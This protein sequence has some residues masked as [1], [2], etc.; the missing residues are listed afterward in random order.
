MRSAFHLFPFLLLRRARS[1]RVALLLFSGAIGS[2]RAAYASAQ[3]HG[4]ELG[5]GDISSGAI[6]SVGAPPSGS[7][8]AVFAISRARASLAMSPVLEER[9]NL[10]EE[11]RRGRPMLIVGSADSVPGE[12]AKGISNRDADARSY[13]L[14]AHPA[15]VK[16]E[17]RVR[18]TSNLLYLRFYALVVAL[19]RF[20]LA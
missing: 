8:L 18:N 16:Q 6:C 13:S 4:R 1:S 9:D 3:Q 10:L 17:P 5:K 15:V 12:G 14:R 7:L 20:Y 11:R 19:E 2:E